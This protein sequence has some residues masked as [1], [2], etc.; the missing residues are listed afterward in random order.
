MKISST[1]G[2]VAKAG[3][4]CEPEHAVL[5][6]YLAHPE[7]SSLPADSVKFGKPAQL[8]L[9]CAALERMEFQKQSGKINS[10]L[11]D[12]IK[13]LA[14]RKLTYTVDA[15]ILNVSR[16][17]GI[18]MPK[19]SK[20]VQLDELQAP[21]PG[22]VPSLLDHADAFAADGP[23][24]KELLESL[25]KL[26]AAIKPVEFWA[27]NKR[28]V[29]RLEALIAQKPVGVPDDGEVWAE[30]ILA[31]I[32]KMSA[33]RRKR[34]RALLE[35]VPKGANAKPTVKW[36]KE[37]DELLA[38]VG[39]EEFAR[40]IE[41]WLGFVGAKAKDRIRLRNATLL[42]SL[43]WY[44]SLLTG[45]TVCRALANAT[46]GGLRKLPAGGL[47]ASSISKSCIAALES[48]TGLEPLAQLS[49]L[50][51]RVKSP[52]GLEEIEKAFANAVARSGISRAEVEEI[53]LP[54]FGLDL[55]GL[56]R[57]GI[58][59]FNAEL[60]VAGTQE[61]ILTW[62]DPSGKVLSK[63]PSLPKNL[64]VEEKALKQLAGDI[65]KMLGAQRDRLEN[66][67]ERGRCWSCANWRARYSEHPLLGQM[68]RR[69]IWQFTEGKQTASG[70]WHEGQ[71]IQEHGKAI[72]WV[73]PNTEVRLWHPI[74]A[75]ATQVLT[76]RNRLEA[77]GI[78]QPFK[79]AHREIY[80][81]TDA[82]LTTR[83]YSNRFA[84]HILRQH[85]FKALCD[86]RGWRYEFLGSWDQPNTVATHDLADW[87][88][89][90]EF[91]IEGA[92]TEYAPSGV[93]LHVATD[94]VRFV[95][96]DQSVCD[97]TD[98]SALVFTEVMRDVDLFV[99][100]CSIGTDPAWHD[101]GENDA[102]MTYWRQFSFDPLSATAKTRREVLER[103]LPRLKIAD[104]CS[105]D[106]RF[107]LVRG[108]LSTYKIHLGSANILMQP[109]DRYLCIVP[110]RGS[111]GSSSLRNI[112]L[113]FEG[114]GVLAVIL[115]KAFL[116][117]DDAN[118][119]DPSIIRQIKG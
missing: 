39:A 74:G 96:P 92:G 84:A 73:G 118:N 119:Q 40:Q 38:A 11:S 5:A 23:L 70:I 94:Q 77:N 28:S 103:L 48:M 49:R 81:L 60:R 50:R 107:L 22:V 62:R 29:Q 66:F 37:A 79:Q 24:P 68:T 52:W 75:A 9:L 4:P 85:Q 47:Y 36:R 53:S 109:N 114:D 30:A 80:L 10:A 91:W 113:P 95:R 13:K 69:L 16:A 25:Q 89:R 14:G 71:L 117:A 42:R 57:R 18:L 83:N 51:H 67:V 43:V 65:E 97:L 2:F 111:A 26:H 64:A 45:E 115:S 106:E 3:Q 19:D 17:A 8:A 35:N 20:S 99:G 58:G 44:A 88:L 55:D 76:W 63:R 59:E 108:E 15:L 1:D 31:D 72:D 90:A 82:E 110:D 33:T 104:R 98:V 93:A 21:I 41:M 116:L 78:T 7:S 100:V 12:L 102:H 105:L 112:F 34:W 27:G 6:D 46:E 32:E 87:D 56:L 101:R 54:T 86:Q 61:V